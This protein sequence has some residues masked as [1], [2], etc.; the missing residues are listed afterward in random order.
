MALCNLMPNAY[1]LVQSLGGN[2]NYVTANV[3]TS[4][5]YT[6]YLNPAAHN[7]LHFTLGPTGNGLA[8]QMAMTQMH[9]TQT[10]PGTGINIRRYF[11]VQ[12]N[13]GGFNINQVPDANKGA[14]RAMMHAD[15]VMY[16]R[17]VQEILNLLV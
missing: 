10:V 8:D 7:D 6:Y 14:A 3:T 11:D 15:Y 12:G 13:L 16:Q 2:G 17:M 5:F 9:I 1:N 4:N